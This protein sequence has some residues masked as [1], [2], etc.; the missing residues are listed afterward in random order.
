MF[1]LIMKVTTLEAHFIRSERDFP[2]KEMFVSD[3]N[4]FPAVS[5][6][7]KYFKYLPTVCRDCQVIKTSRLAAAASRGG[8]QE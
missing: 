2:P 6:G 5:D 3:E 7:E 1:Y 4:G 8:I